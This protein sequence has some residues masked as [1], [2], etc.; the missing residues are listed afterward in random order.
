MKRFFSHYTLIRLLPLADAGEF[1]NIG[2]VLACPET[3]YF[4]FRLMKKQKRVTQFFEEIPRDFLAKLRKELSI[5]LTYVKTLVEDQHLHNELVQ[6]M[7]DLAKPRESMIRYAPLRSIMTEDPAAD[8]AKLFERYVQRDLSIA[9]QYY[10]KMLETL[11][12]RA[13]KHENL[14][15]AFVAEE[16]GS[17]DFH[18]RLPFV[19]EQNGVAIAAIK[20]LDLTQDEPTK[21]YSHGDE[22]LGRIRRLIALNQRPKGFLIAVEGPASE[23]EKRHKA[24]RTIV[25]D[26]QSLPVTVVDRADTQEIVKFAKTYVH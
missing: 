2:V 1:A 17:D 11:V 23:D 10:E 15:E 5:E 13:L 21:I 16:I 19:H 8:L 14:A 6:M 26:L 20:P 18:I 24:Y 12:K 7:Q 4:D 9:P 25:H 22:W 3:G